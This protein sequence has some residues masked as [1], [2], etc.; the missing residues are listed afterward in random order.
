MTS[1]TREVQ[2]DT[3]FMHLRRDVEEI[4]E[5]VSIVYVWRHN[6]VLYVVDYFL[7]HVKRTGRVTVTYEDATAQHSE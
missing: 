4:I 1:Q 5:R 7:A 6:R 3:R 2:P